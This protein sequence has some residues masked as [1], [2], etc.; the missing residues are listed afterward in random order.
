MENLYSVTF[1][2]AGFSH[3]DTSRPELSATRQKQPNWGKFNAK[4]T[5]NVG[6]HPG[7][8]PVAGSRY[9]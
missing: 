5:C 9:G 3:M 6:F 7:N 1:T 2:I 4:G 8:L